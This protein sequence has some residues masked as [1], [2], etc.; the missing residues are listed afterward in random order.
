MTNLL[1]VTCVVVGVIGVLNV[2]LTLGLVGRVRVLQDVV[3][4]GTFPDPDLPKR[5]APVGAFAVTASNGKALSDQDLRADTT[6]VGFF[7]SGCTPCANLR[8]ELV[9]SPPALPFIA[10]VE[11]DHDDPEIHEM[12]QTLSRLG[13]VALTQTGDAVSR[14]FK[15]SGFPTLIR[16]ENGAVA[17]AGHRLRQV[18]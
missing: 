14:A 15:P 1:L 4:D 8:T 10:F 5:G 2:I 11:G 9:R 13:R 6:L 18:L 7:T 12:V 17:A 16:T 3:Q